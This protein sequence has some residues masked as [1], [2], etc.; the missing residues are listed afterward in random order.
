MID[1]GFCP[2]RASIMLAV[3]EGTAAMPPRPSPF[4]SFSLMAPAGHSSLLAK[5]GKLLGWRP[6]TGP[7]R[8]NPLVVDPD[9]W[10]W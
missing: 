10:G 8:K 2:P 3:A 9:D 7:T 1:D 6:P 4:R 5:G